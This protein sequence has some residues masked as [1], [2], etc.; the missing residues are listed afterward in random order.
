MGGAYLDLEPLILRQLQRAGAATRGQ[1]SSDVGS[2]RR[3]GA[4]RG[5]WFQDENH[6]KGVS[7]APGSK[8]PAERSGLGCSLPEGSGRKEILTFKMGAH[9]GVLELART[10]S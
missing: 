3:L 7:K 4:G 10:G 6:R 1:W 2:W 8:G 5:F 9:Q